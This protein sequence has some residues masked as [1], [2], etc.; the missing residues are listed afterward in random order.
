M[1]LRVNEPKKT[2]ARSAR[3]RMRGLNP[4][5]LYTLLSKDIDQEFQKKNA[6][7]PRKWVSTV[8]QIELYVWVNKFCA[9]T[10]G[11]LMCE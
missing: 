2:G 10:Y 9:V 3:E 11:G 1:G 6:R 4:L 5:V 7:S 8:E